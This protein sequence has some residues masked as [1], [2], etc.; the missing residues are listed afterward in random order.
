MPRR[1][2]RARQRNIKGRLNRR[3]KGEPRLQTAHEIPRIP[4]EDLVLPD[5]QCFFPNRNRPKAMFATRQKAQKALDQAKLQRTRS[6]S[7]HV[8]KRYYACPEGG[9]GG[10][11]LT[12]REEYD[13][14]AWKRRQGRNGE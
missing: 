3:Q 9:C 8:E 1:N 2:D 5:G 13:E 6:G 12:S 11:H 4:L 10:Y 14:G 7:A